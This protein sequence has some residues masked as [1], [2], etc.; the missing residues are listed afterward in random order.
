M[1]W[2]GV[3][4]SGKTP[5]FFVPQGITLKKENYVEFLEEKLLPWA[6]AHFGLQNWCFQQDSAPSHKA[7]LTQDWI[8][9]HFPDFITRDEWPSCSPDL[10]PLDYG[11]WSILEK[12]VC[13]KRHHSLQ[14]L[15]DTLVKAW[16]SVSLDIVKNVID[17]FPK[18]LRL[19]VEARG[20]HFEQK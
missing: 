5:L 3:S 16:D 9:K 8:Q 6:S 13:A 15:Q 11:I 12:N 20:G 18:R 10:S 2:A 17:D 19:C 1:V 14:E 4:S 7:N